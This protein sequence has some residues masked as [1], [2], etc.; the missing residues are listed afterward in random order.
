VALLVIAVVTSHSLQSD[1]IREVSTGS[2]A[3]RSVSREFGAKALVFDAAPLRAFAGRVDAYVTARD[4]LRTVFVADHA[5]LYFLD[6]MRDDPQREVILIPH[7]PGIARYSGG[8]FFG[9]SLQNLAH[10][11]Y[12]FDAAEDGP[13]VLIV[14]D[15]GS[16]ALFREQADARDAAATTPSASR[17]VVA[18]QIQSGSLK[19]FS[20]LPTARDDVVWSIPQRADRQ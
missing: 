16:N 5:P 20:V 6:F 18:A 15:K 14:N 1:W 7:D 12:R 13:A 3:Q 19:A 4:D 17:R 2:V 10:R 9:L 11:Y 8:F